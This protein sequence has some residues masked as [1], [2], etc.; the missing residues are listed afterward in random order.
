[1]KNA[2]ASYFKKNGIPDVEPFRKEMINARNEG[3]QL[4]HSRKVVISEAPAA[5]KEKYG[6]PDLAFAIV[7]PFTIAKLRIKFE[8][9]Y[10]LDGR[11]LICEN[12]HIADA[13]GI[14]KLAQN[15]RILDRVHV[16]LPVQAG[17]P[18]FNALEAIDKAHIFGARLTSTATAMFVL[19]AEDMLSSGQLAF[20]Y[21][22]SKAFG[23]LTGDLAIVGSTDS[24]S[25][26]LKFSMNPGDKRAEYNVTILLPWT[27]R[28]FGEKIFTVRDAL[29]QRFDGGAEYSIKFTHLS[30]MHDPHNTL[31]A[32]HNYSL[33]LTHRATIKS[34]QPHFNKFDDK[35]IGFVTCSYGDE[36]PVAVYPLASEFNLL[37]PRPFLV[38]T[39]LDLK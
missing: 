26:D 24:Y 10:V 32:V 21:A 20:N 8:D 1:M 2:A 31:K 39:V 19:T 29:I 6:N 12:E 36:G 27:L 33:Q 14:S 9:A 34:A 37:A 17:L 28:G 4:N 22:V 5:Y 18:K 13:W 25:P 7:A 16:I 15:G 38:E 3:I 35:R 11:K 30:P 23:N